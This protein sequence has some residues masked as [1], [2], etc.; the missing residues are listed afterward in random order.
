MPMY[1]TM[2]QYQAAALKLMVER[3]EDRGAVVNRA[4][5][6]LGGR[7]VSYYW[8]VGNFDGLVILDLPDGTAAAAVQ[9]VMEGTGAVRHVETHEIFPADELPEL[10]QQTARVRYSPPGG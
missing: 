7:V 6:S 3:P 9:L 4:A 1:A 8:S 10:L 2:F 5:E